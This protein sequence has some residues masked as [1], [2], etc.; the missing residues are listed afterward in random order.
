MIYA[1]VLA[2]GESKRMGR[3]KQLL[4]F[5]RQT[6]IEAV[7]NHVC[8]SG[9]DKVLVILGANRED[10]TQRL[11]KFPVS[12]V[13]NPHYKD[14]MLSSI[15]RGFEAMAKDATAALI[16]LGDQPTIP[17][18]VIDRIIDAFHSSGKGIVVP[19]YNK[20]RGHPV[21]IDIKYRKDVAALDPAVGLRALVHEH[22]EDVE[23][24]VVESSAILM[25]IDYPED[26]RKAFHKQETREKSTE[27]KED[28]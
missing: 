17:G 22:T 16:I 6:L 18:W 1:I 20:R 2:A 10:I 8:H 11:E 7:V 27:K 24:A 9:V 14:G 19:V 15:Q 13:F 25:D 23:E 4:P 3:P 5:G 21:L 12:T 28:S 26:Y